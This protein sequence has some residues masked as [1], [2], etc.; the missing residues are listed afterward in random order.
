VVLAV[1]QTFGPSPARSFLSPRRLPCSLVASFRSSCALLPPL[2]SPR[3]TAI[4]TCCCSLLVFA[5]ASVARS[6]CRV[7]SCFPRTGLFASSPYNATV[8]AI[9]SPQSLLFLSRA[10]L[11]RA[12]QLRYA[13]KIPESAESE[14]YHGPR[15]ALHGLLITC[16]MK[17]TSS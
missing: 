11:S 6:L 2:D 9:V 4:S 1:G 12:V 13:W 5:L 8:C 7:S 10:G 17:L 16:R 14:Q 15:V 3:R